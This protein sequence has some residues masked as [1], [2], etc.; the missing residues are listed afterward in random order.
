M[1]RA[2]IPAFAA[3]LVATA[4]A[5][6]EEVESPIY[7]SWAKH[8]VGTVVKYRSVTSSKGRDV[9]SIIAY[10]LTARDDKKVVVE[11]VVTS[12]ATGKKVESDPQSFTTRRMFPLLPGVKKE[13]IGKPRG[14]TESGEETVELAGKAYKAQWYGSK[15]RTE[16]GESL[17]RTWMSDEVPGKLLKS[18][19]DV[20]AADKKTTVELIEIQAP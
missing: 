2:L 3:L 6:A 19:T 11:M 7:R 20:P 5:P 9:E 1:T 17:T 8:E 15:G 18:V 14:A 16:A 4:T 12:D 10:R 13:D